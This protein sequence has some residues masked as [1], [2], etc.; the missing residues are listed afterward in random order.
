[1]RLRSSPTTSR[2][3]PTLSGILREFENGRGGLTLAEIARK[4]DI[5]RSAL[6]GMIQLLVRK[7]RLREVCGPGGACSACNLRV[8]CGAGHS[9]GPPGISYELVKNGP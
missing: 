1:M 8:V 6:E 4:L 2:G 9:G 5:E 7:G 3:S